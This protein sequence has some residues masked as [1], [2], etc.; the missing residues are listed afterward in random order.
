[1]ACRRKGAAAKIREA[2]QAY[3]ESTGRAKKAVIETAVR[4]A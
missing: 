1:M 2:S 3:S 4:K